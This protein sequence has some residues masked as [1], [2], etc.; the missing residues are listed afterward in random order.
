MR[1]SATNVAGL[2]LRLDEEE[3]AEIEAR[4]SKDPL[5]IY[6]Y[7]QTCVRADDYELGAPAERGEAVAL[8]P[9]PVF[10]LLER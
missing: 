8:R 5:Y 4:F 7:T 9:V 2:Q 1:P 6:I 10:C 3:R